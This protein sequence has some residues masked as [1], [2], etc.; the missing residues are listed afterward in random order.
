MYQALLVSFEGDYVTDFEASTM[1]EVKELLSNRGSRWIF[2]P[3]EFVIKSPFNQNGRII[4]APSELSFVKGKRIGRVLQA[5]RDMVASDL[6]GFVQ[7]VA[8]QLCNSKAALR[9][10]VLYRTFELDDL[11]LVRGPESSLGP[12]FAVCGRYGDV[13]VEV[14]IV[15]GT[16][17]IVRLSRGE[18]VITMSARKGRLRRKVLTDVVRAIET[19]PQGR[20]WKLRVGAAMWKRLNTVERGCTFDKLLKEDV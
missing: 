15:D 14:M 3:F 1:E 18:V 11:H 13:H 16:P 4:D 9:W 5:F 17:T 20:L 10:D 6:E 2:Y 19:S 12:A 7:G 8:S